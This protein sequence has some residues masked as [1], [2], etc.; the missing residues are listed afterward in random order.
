LQNRLGELP[1]TREAFSRGELSYGKVSTLVRVAE[2]A[3]EEKLVELAGFL[4]ASQLERAVGA[5]RRISREEA[6]DQ[7]DRES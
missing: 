1:L 7:Q 6:A 3:N 5:Y 2:P 4:T